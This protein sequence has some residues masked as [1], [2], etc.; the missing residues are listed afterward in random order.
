MLNGSACFVRDG[1]V[2]NNFKIIYRAL[3]NAI[4]NELLT[5]QMKENFLEMAAAELF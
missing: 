3:L 5:L 2:T 4:R 1:Y